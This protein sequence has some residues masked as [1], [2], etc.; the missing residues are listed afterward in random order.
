MNGTEWIRPR[1]LKHDIRRPRKPRKRRHSMTVCIAAICS[2]VDTPNNKTEAVIITAS[3]RMITRRGD[4]EY[5][6][7][8]P[9]LLHISRSAS[10]LF[11]GDITVHSEA[12]QKTR[13]ALDASV[14]E[15]GEIAELY[16]SFVRAFREREAAQT[17]LSPLGLTS[18]SLLAEADS[19][20][21]DRLRE[22]IQGHHLDAEAIVIGMDSVGAGAHIYHVDGRGFVTC[23]DEVGFLAIGIGAPHAESQI[24][25]FKYAPWWRYFNT[26][27]MLYSAKK[28]AEVA[29]GVGPETDIFFLPKLVWNLCETT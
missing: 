16:A 22:Q 26:V 6:P 10:V 29:P 24:M 13:A 15:V 4:S 12:V 23:H 11:A 19:Q 9:K 1:P 25:A 8:Q 7:P 5:E 28:R 21:A 2:W 20:L 14:T 27:A 3:D 17:Y 18:K